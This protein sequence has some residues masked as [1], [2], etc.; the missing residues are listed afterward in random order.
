MMKVNKYM[1]RQISVIVILLVAVLTTSVS[2]YENKIKYI[3]CFY[4]P[5]TIHT[6]GC[7][8]ENDIREYKNGYHIRLDIDSVLNQFEDA[9]GY[10]NFEESKYIETFD[11]RMVL[12]LK[13]SNGNNSV[14][15]INR[16][17]TIK[18][19]SSL[20]RNVY[21]TNVIRNNIPEQ[22]TLKGK[23]ITSE[24]KKGELSKKEIEEYYKKGI[25]IKEVDQ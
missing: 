2:I 13:L 5:K 16:V 11:T 8:S 14:I 21:L 6:K 1:N 10:Y 15:Q 19:G 24:V 20:Y 22:L 7:L 18:I 23:F 25:I 17:N 4:I 12:D 3:D 9:V